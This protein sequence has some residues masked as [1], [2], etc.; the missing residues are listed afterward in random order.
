MF[1]SMTLI[2]ITWVSHLKI[3][4]PELGSRGRQALGRV[5]GQRPAGECEGQR[6]SE[7]EDF[8]ISKTN[9]RGS[10]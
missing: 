6:P 2:S 10:P 7:A 5:Q 8:L 1:N 4:N 9:L 3:E